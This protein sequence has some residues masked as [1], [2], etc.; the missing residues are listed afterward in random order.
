MTLNELFQAIKSYLHF[1]QISS[2][3]N[4]LKGQQQQQNHNNIAYRLVN[5]NNNTNYLKRNDKKNKK[6]Y[7]NKMN[8]LYILFLKINY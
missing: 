8:Y 3:L 1:S 2:W 5:N 7:S 4:Q 6:Q